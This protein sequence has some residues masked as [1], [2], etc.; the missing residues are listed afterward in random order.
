M[1]DS[2]KPSL[3]CDNTI[4]EERSKKKLEP[5]GEYEHKQNESDKDGF[6]NE[7]LLNMPEI[8]SINSQKQPIAKNFDDKK[9]IEMAVVNT[10]V[11]TAT[12]TYCSQQ[13]T[14]T[15]LRDLFKPSLGT[16]IQLEKEAFLSSLKLIT[17]GLEGD[18][19]T[20]AALIHI[21]KRARALGF[22]F[23]SDSDT[24]G[25]TDQMATAEE[26]IADG[27][28][29]LDCEDFAGMITFWGHAAADEGYL[30]EGSEFVVITGKRHVVTKIA[31]V[32]SVFISP[33]GDKY[34]MDGNSLVTHDLHTLSEYQK[35][36]GRL[37]FIQPNVARKR[38]HTDDI[39]TSFPKDKRIVVKLD[40]KLY[41]T[42]EHAM[43]LIK[44]SD[45][46]ISVEW[47]NKQSESP[48]D[49]SISVD[50]LRDK[51]YNN[52]GFLYY[53]G[54]ERDHYKRYFSKEHWGKADK[55]IEYPDLISHH[56]GMSVIEGSMA[57]AFAI[58][59]RYKVKR[60]RRNIIKAHKVKEQWI[61]K[62]VSNAEMS[63]SDFKDFG[64]ISYMVDSHDNKNLTHIS[65]VFKSHKSFK[66]PASFYSLIQDLNALFID[67]E[68]LLNLEKTITE[69]NL[70]KRRFI[71]KDMGEA[72]KKYG[73]SIEYST[74]GG[75]RSKVADKFRSIDNKKLQ[76][77]LY[78]TVINKKNFIKY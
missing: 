57:T 54:V 5:L 29:G 35:V 7:P 52:N 66:T 65:N 50:D 48:I 49:D 28:Q 11:S 6:K 71:E 37:N 77:C 46:R 1:D 63:L 53:D 24:D 31:H 56:L 43:D 2:Y 27:G 21:Q 22:T 76:P 72:L 40:G 15:E 32:V 55:F 59:K 58:R 67:D 78:K 42:K 62:K 4:I 41:S 8:K 17:K 36:D 47:L 60:R 20:K 70:K 51:I 44:V 10:A 34:I 33:D 25:V 69:E 68:Q 45:D 14:L 13:I 16:T 61:A 39:V 9:D 19:K 26:I 30:P 12:G 74:D 75:I 38:F 64:Y 18:E 73:I 3:I 23:G